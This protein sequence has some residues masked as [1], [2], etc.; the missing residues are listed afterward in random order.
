MFD[1]NQ[2]FFFFE[3]RKK[4][5]E[6]RKAQV[7]AAMQQAQ[8][9]PQSQM[10]GGR[11]ITPHWSEALAPALIGYMALKEGKQL[12][13]DQSEYDKADQAAALAHQQSRPQPSSDGT[14]P[15]TKQQ[16]E[17]AQKGQA[18][19]S[20]KA[21]MERVIADLEVNEPTRQEARATKASDRED[22]QAE[23][24]ASLEANLAFKREQLTQAAENA[25][26]VAENTRLSIEQRREA[27]QQHNALMAQLAADRRAASQA[28][29]TQG[30]TLPQGALKDLGAL[31]DSATSIS[32]LRSEFLPEYAGLS[33]AAKTIA[34]NVI[35][36]VQTDAG[37][38]WKNYRKEASLVERHSLF[39]ASL[40]SNEQQSWKSADI[41]PSMSS[42]TIET[43]LARREAFTRKMFSNAANRQRGAGYNVDSPF[44]NAANSPTPNAATAENTKTVNGVT[45]VKRG[46]QWFAQ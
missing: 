2:P 22:R 18:I 41:D 33:G 26:A 9:L 40:T 29:T 4:A 46:S 27:A 38:W 17:W 24:K 28:T 8:N 23:A 3:Q 6:Q 19:P 36:G 15:T 32:K 30:K 45:Y 35:P 1:P 13:Q 11:L 31:E 14:P 43:N 34:A 39:G 21:V 12:D 44:P 20:R 42:K 7:A 25:K 10:V 5:L 37:D 16:L